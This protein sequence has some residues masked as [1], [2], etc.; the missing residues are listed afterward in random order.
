VDLL[1]SL[2][3]GKPQNIL[4]AAV[5]F[6][7]GYLAL[8]FTAL[9]ISRHPRPLLIAS[10]AW[11]FYAAWER[12]VQIRTPEANIRVDLLVIW[13]VLAILSAWALFRA[14]R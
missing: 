4:A 14:F 9:G 6:L 11:G 7:A 8:R 5:V 10:A 1:T 12:L 13:P 2:F 3:V